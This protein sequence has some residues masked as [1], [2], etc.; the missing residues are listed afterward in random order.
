MTK[1][2]DHLWL[3]RFGALFGAPGALLLAMNAPF[4]KYGWLLFLA[5]NVAWV[6][7]ALYKRLRFLLAQQLI[8][9]ATTLLG[10]YRFFF[11]GFV[12]SFGFI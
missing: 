12:P 2:I 4:S 11:V 8:F 9:T 6:G 7:F 3:E 1:S 5:S 10:I